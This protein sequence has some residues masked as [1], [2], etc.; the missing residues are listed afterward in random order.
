[1]KGSKFSDLQKA[2]IL[3]QTAYLKMIRVDNSGAPISHERDSRTS[4]DD[5][6]LLHDPANQLETGTSKRSRITIPHKNQD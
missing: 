5:V 4:A 3:M 6:R 2:F 1:M